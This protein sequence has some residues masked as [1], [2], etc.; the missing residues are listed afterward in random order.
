MR[1]FIELRCV[2]NGSTSSFFRQ[3]LESST[4]RCHNLGLIGARLGLLP[5][6]AP[7]VNSA[8]TAL[9][10]EPIAHPNT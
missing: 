7:F 4:Y 9:R 8:M 10:G 3:A 5:P 1:G 6:L 2:W